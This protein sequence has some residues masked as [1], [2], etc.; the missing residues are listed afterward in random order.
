MSRSEQHAA[1]VVGLA[2][3]DEGKGTILDFL[4]RRH[5]AHTIVRFNGGPQAAH[6]VATEDGRRHTFA[7]FGAGSFVPGVRT[8]LSR[9]VLV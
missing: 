2:F 4:T 9:F 3:G 7:Q 1:I 8:L 6:G 5:G